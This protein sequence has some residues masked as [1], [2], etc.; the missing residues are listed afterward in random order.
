[1]GYNDIVIQPPAEAKTGHKLYP[2]VV[3]K[4]EREGPYLLLHYFMARTSYYKVE[5][6]VVDKINI[7]HFDQCN[8]QLHC[9]SAH[10][11]PKDRSI[12]SNDDR[13]YFCFPNPVLDEPGEYRIRIDLI[14]LCKYGPQVI[15]ENLTHKITRVITVKDNSDYCAEL[16]KTTTKS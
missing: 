8:G 3:V 11:L 14:K 13:A 16:S 12:F 2:P 10:P 4:L 9:D 6:G 5:G 1:M 15:H 7:L